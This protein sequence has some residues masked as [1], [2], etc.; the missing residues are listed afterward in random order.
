MQG[1]T[2]SCNLPNLGRQAHAH[3]AGHPVKILTNGQVL[4]GSLNTFT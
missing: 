2:P 3:T 4:T 1:P